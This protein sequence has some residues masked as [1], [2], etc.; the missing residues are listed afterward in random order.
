MGPPTGCQGWEGTSGHLCMQTS[1]QGMHATFTYTYVSTIAITENIIA[2]VTIWRNRHRIAYY[3]QTWTAFTAPVMVIETFWEPGIVHVG[4]W[5]TS[6][7]AW[8][9]LSA[10]SVSIFSYLTQPVCMFVGW[11]KGISYGVQ[12]IIQF[13][14]IIIINITP[15]KYYKYTYVPWH[16]AVSQLH[17]EYSFQLVELIF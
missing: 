5:S 4:S 2:H 8:P 10:I 1:R 13:P 7:V 9:L 16:R 12:Y 15:L 14:F 11:L 3:W 17:P 6:K